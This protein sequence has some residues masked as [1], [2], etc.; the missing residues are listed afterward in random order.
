VPEAMGMA[1]IVT[2]VVIVMSV[3]VLVVV[4]LVHASIPLAGSAMC[5]NMVESRLLMWASAAE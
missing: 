3:S 1:V 4:C 5:S 2:V